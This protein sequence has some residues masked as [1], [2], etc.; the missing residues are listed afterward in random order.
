MDKDK[1]AVAAALV[2][3][4]AF[5]IFAAYLFSINTSLQGKLDALNASS[6]QQLVQAQ[7]DYNE[8]NSRYM[9]A[10]KQLR[11]ANAA[12]DGANAGLA[13]VQAQLAEAK[14]QL[15]ESRASLASQQQYVSEI[16]E[17]L[18]KLQASINESM[19]WFRENSYM[20]KNYSWAGDIFMTR[21][22]SDCVDAGRLN[23]AC[24]S[25][26][27]ENTAFAIHYREDIEAGKEDHLQS[28]KE[29]IDLGWGDC[30]DYSLLF[31]AVLN[32]M[33]KL[34]ASLIATA[35][36]PAQSG[37]FRIYPKEAPDESGPY[38]AYTKAK[39]APL[40]QLSNYYVVCYTMAPTAGHCIVAMSEAQVNDSS[41]VPLLDG[42]EL[43]E[44]QSGGYRGRM[45]ESLYICEQDGCRNTGGRA[46]LVISDS[47][48]YI[49][50][51]GWKGYA[52]T[53]RQVQEEETSLP[54]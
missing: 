4:L 35:W 33:R 28:L 45:G 23:L 9:V 14:L 10:Q 49:Y 53:L 21:I 44:P 11:D 51:G 42:A 17:N 5:M 1:V 25:H 15:A 2:F 18:T 34:N 19:S 31:K 41:Q 27:M 13:Q 48:L 24:I 43:F 46:W 3:L 47:D 26:L 16:R 30:E 40:G 38:W 50:D 22:S 39:A 36:Q 20:P 12:L 37:E 52:D 8:V 54:A 7:K 32:S 29:T 6:A